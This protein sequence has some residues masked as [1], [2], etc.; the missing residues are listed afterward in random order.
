MVWYG[1]TAE[2]DVTGIIC[3]CADMAHVPDESERIEAD[4][5]HIP[6]CWPELSRR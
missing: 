1:F 3:N 2:G 4:A 6:Y 5:A